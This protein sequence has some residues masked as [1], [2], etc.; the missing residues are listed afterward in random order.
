[1]S[2]ANWLSHLQAQAS[3]PFF[4]RGDKMMAV[5]QVEQ[6]L[7]FELPVPGALRGATHRLHELQRSPRS[8]RHDLEPAHRRG[9]GCA[10]RLHRIRHRSVP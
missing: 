2:Y 8:F 9:R 4:D 3:D 10:H 5:S 7:K 1:V 6:S